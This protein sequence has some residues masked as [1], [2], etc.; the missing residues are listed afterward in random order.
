MKKYIVLMV[1]LLAA[2]LLLSACNQAS[3]ATPAAPA[4]TAIPPTMPA[5]VPTA[6]KPSTTPA[7][8][9]A[10]GATKEGYPA[11]SGAQSPAGQVGYPAPGAEVQV[12]AP[13]GKTKKIAMSALMGIAKVKVPVNGKDMELR[14][15]ADLFNVAGI[16][17]YKTVTVV[18]SNG[19]LQLTGDQPGKAFLDVAVD[20]TIKLVIDGV[21]PEKWITGVTQVSAQ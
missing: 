12:K 9:P 3:T 11:P 14:K 2:V 15:L 7:G 5:V 6:G 1:V 10:P 4:A 8:Y 18:G 13:D 20:G 17:A 16:A 21:Q 19:Q